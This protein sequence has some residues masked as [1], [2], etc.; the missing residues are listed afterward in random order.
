[1]EEV[2]QGSNGTDSHIVTTIPTT[3][4]AS[5]ISQIAQQV[6]HNISWIYLHV[7]VNNYLISITMYC[8]SSLILLKPLSEYGMHIANWKVSRPHFFSG[9]I[10]FNPIIT[11]LLKGKIKEFRAL[12]C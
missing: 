6:K 7:Y 9:L 2:Q 12:S 5:Q 10:W 3:I 8:P 4:T 11:N 1:M